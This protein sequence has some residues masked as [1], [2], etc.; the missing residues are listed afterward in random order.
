[1]ER[2]RRGVDA[3]RPV[4]WTSSKRRSDP[5]T[6][7]RMDVAPEGAERDRPPAGMEQLL[8]SLAHVAG[9]SERG[10]AHH[11]AVGDRAAEV[12]AVPGRTR[13]VA[14]PNALAGLHPGTR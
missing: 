14:P 6:P 5:R 12:L 3:A 1:M 2:N 10:R 11:V 4:D 13:R 9:S 7:F 8:G